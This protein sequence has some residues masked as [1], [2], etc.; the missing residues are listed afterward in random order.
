MS[1]CLFVQTAPFLPLVPSEARGGI[2]Q[3][4]VRQGRQG[5][6]PPPCCVQH[7]QD[8]A[9]LLFVRPDE[10]TLAL[11]DKWW[12]SDF[13]VHCGP[14]ILPRQTAAMENLSRYIIRASFSQE[15]LGYDAQTATV[16][17]KCKDGM[18]LWNGWPPC[19]RTSPIRASRWCA[20]TATIATCPGASAKKA[21]TMA[22]WP[23][24]WN[25]PCPTRLSARTGHG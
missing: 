3:V 21:G 14:R 4:V 13:I 19:V 23:M 15:R 10:A 6:A 9:P 5:R 17:Y 24:F 7:P 20:I 16:V 25:R 18:M 12:H 22:Q 1:T 2:R 11:I 8:P